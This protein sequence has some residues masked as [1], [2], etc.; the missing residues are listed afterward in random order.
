[1]STSRHQFNVYFTDEQYESNLIYNCLYYNAAEHLA[2]IEHGW[3]GLSQI[4]PY[5]IRSKP[6]GKLTFTSLNKNSSSYTFNELRLKQITSEQLV[7]WSAPIDLAEHYQMYFHN[8]N[9]LLVNETFNNCSRPWF[10]QFC[11]FRFDEDRS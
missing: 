4:I 2:G 8:S 6:D 10:G 9:E 1:M 7:E 11:Q 3:V 5:C